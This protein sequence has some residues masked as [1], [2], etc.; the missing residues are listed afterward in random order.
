[1]T[2]FTALADVD[3]QQICGGQ[4]TGEPS[5]G[6]GDGDVVTT[7]STSSTCWA[8]PMSAPGRRLA[9]RGARGRALGRQSC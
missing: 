5:D 3:C 6:G 2:L 7:T 1:M 4:Y 8:W 9:I